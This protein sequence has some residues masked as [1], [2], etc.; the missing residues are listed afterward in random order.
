M[1]NRASGCCAD[2]WSFSEVL[3]PSTLPFADAAGGYGMWDG[4]CGMR[5]VLEARLPFKGQGMDYVETSGRQAQRKRIT[6]RR[7]GEG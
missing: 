6:S 5:R 2:R 3:E 7:M 1:A 4:V